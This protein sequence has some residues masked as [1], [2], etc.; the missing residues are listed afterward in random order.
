M[1]RIGDPGN[2]IIDIDFSRFPASTNTNS[3]SLS[4]SLD[5]HGL[6]FLRASPATVQTSATSVATGI[7][8]NVIRIGRSGSLSNT[9]LVLEETRTNYVFPHI[10]PVANTGVWGDVANATASYGAA[11]NGIAEATRVLMVAGTY[12]PHIYTSVTS[13]RFISLW[14]RRLANSTG[15]KQRL[16]DGVELPSHDLTGYS[17]DTWVRAGRYHNSGNNTYSIHDNRLTTHGGSGVGVDMLSWG[18]QIENGT[19]LTELIETSGSVQTRAAER[20]YH[21]DVTKLMHDGMLAIEVTFRPK[22]D[23]PSGFTKPM[24]I[25][26]IDENN[27]FEL[28]PTGTLAR[29]CINGEFATRNDLS[30]KREEAFNFYTSFFTS[31][32]E[33]PSFKGVVSGTSVNYYDLTDSTTGITTLRLSASLTGSIN[34]FSD[35]NGNKAFSAWVEHISVYRRARNVPNLELDGTRHQNYTRVPRIKPFKDRKY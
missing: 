2:T 16:Y 17:G 10:T 32:A 7:P 35:K 6:T 18:H 4:G 25:W 19:F 28:D 22:A 21:P 15:Y 29:F 3:G 30:L 12:G 34:F 1:A 26:S 23:F 9:A 20:L 24:R 27:Y 33:S 8:N 14:G 5:A 31:R 11:P 13:A